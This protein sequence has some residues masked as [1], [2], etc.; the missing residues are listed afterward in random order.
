MLL[1]PDSLNKLDCN[2]TSDMIQ[3]CFAASVQKHVFNTSGFSMRL[4]L[5]SPEMT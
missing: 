4:L 3:P 1:P 2:L 5:A